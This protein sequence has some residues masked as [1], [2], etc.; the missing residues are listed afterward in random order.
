MCYNYIVVKYVFAKDT[1]YKHQV[2]FQIYEAAKSLIIS[3]SVFKF[4]KSDL[5]RAKSD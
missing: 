1:F 5:K 4:S 2:V 3:K